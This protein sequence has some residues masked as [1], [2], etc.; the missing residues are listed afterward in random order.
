M[1]SLCISDDLA[2]RESFMSQSYT[3]N[4]GHYSTFVFV[5]VLLQVQIH[6]NLLEPMDAACATFLSVSGR[7]CVQMRSLCNVLVHPENA[8]SRACFLRSQVRA[9][10]C[11]P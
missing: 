11:M 9:G 1:P 4:N 10:V 2:A 3:T 7:T 6:D 5:F 8:C